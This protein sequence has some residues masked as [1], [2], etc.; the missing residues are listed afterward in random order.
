MKFLTASLALV[1]LLGAGC[2]APRA[3]DTP[4]ATAK[5]EEITQKLVDVNAVSGAL[6]EQASLMVQIGSMG[7]DA[8]KRDEWAKR[9]QEATV[10]MREKKLTE[11][12]AL[13]NAVNAEM[14]AVIAAGKK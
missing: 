4:E 13:V 7:V 1:I 10:L 3:N 5:K 14:R 8:R 12:L 2:G 9:V 11:A 6:R